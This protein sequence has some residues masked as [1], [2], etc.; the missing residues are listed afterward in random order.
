MNGKQETAEHRAHI[1]EGT[2]RY[3]QKIGKSYRARFSKIACEYIDELNKK[4]NWNLQHALNGGEISV[5]PYYLD[6]YD[7]DLN[8][9]FEYDE[10]AHYIDINNNILS[11]H[12]I[13]R[14]QYIKEQLHC[15]FIRYNARL[16]L[17]YEC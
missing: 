9:A 13:S 12:D 11:E 6:G 14:M 15:K 1:A 17:L 10:P 3:L 4:N 2:K 5:G 16:K 7:K 8:I